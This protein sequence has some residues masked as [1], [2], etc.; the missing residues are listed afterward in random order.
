M[1]GKKIKPRAILV[2]GAP[3]SGKTTF[4]ENFAKRFSAPF[5]NLDEIQDQLKLS[6]T[7][8]LRFLELLVKTG[9]NLV[10]EGGLDTEEQRR[11]IYLLLK[12]AGY[13]HSLVWIQT[14][15]QTIKKRLASSLKS[16]QK[17]KDLYDQ[18][19]NTLEAPTDLESPIVLSGKHTF[20]TQLAHV[21]TRLA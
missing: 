9:Q 5:Y 11:R 13:H 20:Q 8:L 16:I 14:D 2:F 18:K 21:L 6:K 15:T 12:Q 17:A 19:I 7:S 1:E 4:A 10:I 3:C